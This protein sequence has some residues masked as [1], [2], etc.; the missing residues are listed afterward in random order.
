MTQSFGFN[1][2]S[3]GE[4]LA[5]GA[6]HGD[7]SVVVVEIMEDQCRD[8]VAGSEA[9]GTVAVKVLA[10][11]LFEVGDDAAVDFFIEAYCVAKESDHAGDQSWWGDQ[12]LVIGRGAA[13]HL[14]VE[15]C[16]AA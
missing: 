16:I 13:F 6:S 15:C 2:G 12:D 10:V 14:C 5:N 8:G 4:L 1:E 9:R 7:G 3:L 11:D